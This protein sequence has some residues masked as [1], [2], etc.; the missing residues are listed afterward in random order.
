MF[1][2][3]KKVNDEFAN[4]DFSNSNLESAVLF[5]TSVALRAVSQSPRQL[6]NIRATCEY[7]GLGP[8]H[9]KIVYFHVSGNHHVYFDFHIT[10]AVGCGLFTP[11]P[12]P[13]P[14]KNILQYKG[15]SRILWD[16]GSWDSPKNNALLVRSNYMSSE[17]ELPEYT[18]YNMFGV[19][20]T[21]DSKRLER[22]KT[23]MNGS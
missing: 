18:L 11:N 15:V 7:L 8:N 10:L 16:A 20:I 21:D 14:S 3:K 23:I 19:P 13:D 9:N 12:H 1:N 17:N 22:L 2:K 4:C 6:S 5:F